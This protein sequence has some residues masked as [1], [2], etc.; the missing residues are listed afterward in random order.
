MTHIQT[1]KIQ[2]AEYDIVGK[3]AENLV[4]VMSGGSIQDFFFRIHQK[5]NQS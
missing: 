1:K 5:N 3:F 2:L 4:E